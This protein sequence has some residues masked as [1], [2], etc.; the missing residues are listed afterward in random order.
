MPAL[1][2]LL[3]AGWIAA[4]GCAAPLGWTLQW[5]QPLPRQGP[6]G[7]AI[8]GFSA[9]AHEPQQ[10]RIW[11]LSDLPQ[12]ELSA[13]TLPGQRSAP[14]LLLQRPIGSTGGEALDGEGLVLAGDQLWIASEG[15]R[16]ADRPALLLR[17]NRRDGRPLQRVPL[18]AAWQAAP[19]LGL[20]SNAGPESL[21][22]LSAP[23]EPLQLL[24]A[25]ERPLLQDPDGQVRL[26]RWWWPAGRPTAAEP[27]ASPQG[28]LQ[29][30]GPEP[31]SLT[32]LLAL[33]RRAGQPPR[34]LALL[35]RYS[36]PQSWENRLA[37]Y[38]L[39]QPGGVASPLQIWDLQ[40]AGLT[41]ENWEGLALG[42]PQANGGPSLLL[43][44]D[45]N[46]NPLQSSRLALLI[47]NP[48]HA[49]LEHP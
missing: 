32:D 48:P 42:P 44:S 24:M 18:P 14:R 17:V 43:V 13:W 20:A 6:S 35:R 4:Q 46:L 3:T 12:A 23:G 36:P 27:Q 7:E 22:R 49:C 41:P 28:S 15:R 2:A 38:P 40:Q 37:L 1:T 8:G 16:T 9:I 47:P 5:E 11:L 21:T 19:G 33:P 34:L 45:D 25:A 29:L 30:P 39:P 26:L 10:G 31:W